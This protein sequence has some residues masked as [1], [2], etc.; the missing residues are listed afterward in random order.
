MKHATRRVCVVVTARASYSR[1]RTALRAIEAHPALELKLVAAGSAVLSRYGNVVHCIRGDGFDV[2]AQ[3]H[4]LLEGENLVTSAKSTGLGLSDL[5]TVF[6]N[7]VPDVVVSIADRYE[8]LSASIAAA[9]MNIPL[10]HVQ[11]GEVTG[12][13]DEKVRHANTKL[14]DLHFVAT[15]QARRFVIRMGEEP[16]RVFN[17]G[18]PSIDLAAEI[19]HRPELP[20]ASAAELGGVGDDFDLQQDY[21]IVLQHPVTT[22]CGDAR[23]QIEATLR[24]VRQTGVPTLWFWPNADAGSELASGGIRAFREAENPRGIRF[25]KHVDSLD[26]LRLV[27][28]SRTLVG[29]SSVALRECA[30]LGVPAVN[31]GTRQ[32][33]RLRGENVLDTE[34]DE[35]Q[36]VRAIAAQLDHGRYPRDLRYGRGDAGT[37]MAALLATAP[38][39]IGKRLTYCET[40]GKRRERS[41]TEL[42]S[43][44]RL[45]PG[46]HHRAPRAT[47]NLALAA[48]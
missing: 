10:V 25:L 7:L 43:A 24:A 32:Q 16:L 8:T 45:P 23:S 17:T 20:C 34:H 11:G 47:K 28:G 21:L 40:R 44:D 42:L 2:A 19:L 48:V 33:G 12:S 4:M 27:H 30:Y 9:Y 29:N 3:V 1:I 36:I 38:L 39:K 37:K 35:R 26:F 15:E 6:D 13:I 22:E 46:T 31:I 14:A 41:A 5:A 18:C